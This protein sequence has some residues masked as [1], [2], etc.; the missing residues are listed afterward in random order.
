[1]EL[2]WQMQILE[3][4]HI[5]SRSR[6]SSVGVVTRLRV[7]TSGVRNSARVIEFFLLQ[8]VPTVLYFNGYRGSFAQ[9]KRSKLSADHSTFKAEVENKWSYTSTPTIRLRLVD[10]DSFTFYLTFP[11]SFCATQFNYYNSNS[12]TKPDVPS[13]V[14]P[15]ITSRQHMTSN[16]TPIFLPTPPPSHTLS[17]WNPEHQLL[18]LQVS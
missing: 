16:F 5:W 13:G 4:F 2:P 12:R 3:S 6:C 17:A 15:S 11:V 1:M 7:G 14:W 18:R 8:D 10:R 9:V